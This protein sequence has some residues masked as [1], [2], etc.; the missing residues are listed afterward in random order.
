MI[1]QPLSACCCSG[2]WRLRNADDSWQIDRGRGMPSGLT[3][4]AAIRQI[5]RYLAWSAAKEVKRYYYAIDRCVL[6][7]I[8]GA[9]GPGQAG[10]RQVLDLLWINSA[11]A[12]H[13][14]GQPAAHRLGRIAAQ[15][16]LCRSCKARGG[17][18]ESPQAC[19]S[20]RE[21]RQ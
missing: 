11:F 19:R 12:R 13:P 1:T 15:L 20:R 6:T 17:S 5:H 10:R 3:H 21:A 4:G 7:F 16:A 18:F 9:S 2:R 8:A 14:K